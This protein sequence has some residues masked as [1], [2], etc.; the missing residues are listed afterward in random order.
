MVI[1]ISLYEWNF[2]FSILLLGNHSLSYYVKAIMLLNYYQNHLLTKCY[3]YLW[4]RCCKVVICNNWNIL[5]I[6]LAIMFVSLRHLMQIAM[7]TF[8][9]IVCDRALSL[10]CSL[11][12]ML[13]IAH[14]LWM[15]CDF[16]SFSSRMLSIACA[17]W[18]CFNF[19]SFYSRNG[20]LFLLIYYL[21]CFENFR[22]FPSSCGKAY[23]GFLRNKQACPPAFHSWCEYLVC[24]LLFILNCR[25]CYLLIMHQAVGYFIPLACV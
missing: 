5:L 1:S 14:E 11:P 8:Y 16:R 22:S 7:T 2:R 21:L 4:V 10:S 12:T 13:S 20:Y 18:I 15:C 9:F 19:G 6:H 25:E 3:F 23:S 17:L 24:D